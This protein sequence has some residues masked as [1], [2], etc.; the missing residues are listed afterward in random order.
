VS[1]EPITPKSLIPDN[2][3][4]TPEQKQIV[5]DNISLAIKG[6][7]DWLYTKAHGNM[8]KDEL[9]SAASLGLIHGV[10]HYKKNINDPGDKRW[11]SYI[12]TCI[13]GFILNE[14]RY[15]GLIYIPFDRRKD[16]L[17]IRKQG[18]KNINAIKKARLKVIMFSLN[19]DLVQKIDN[20]DNIINY[21]IVKCDIYDNIDLLKPQQK[22]IISLFLDGASF[23]NIEKQLKLKHGAAYPLCRKILNILKKV[24]NNE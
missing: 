15:M 1:N 16:K 9:I 10:T 7:K 8:T 2:S 20:I 12:L 4:L 6:A 18:K 17:F 5:E 19:I 21:D 3:K 11:S 14:L 24:I 13:N 23:K 22:E